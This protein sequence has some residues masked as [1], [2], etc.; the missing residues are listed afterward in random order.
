MRRFGVLIALT[1]LVV[2][3]GCGSSGDDTKATSTTAAPRSTTTTT[4]SPEAQ[5]LQPVVDAGLLRLTDLP[6]DFVATPGPARTNSDRIIKNLDQCEQFR[7]LTQHG[8]TSATSSQ[9]TNRTQSAFDTVDVFA[10]PA[11]AE[12]K[13]TL[14]ENPRII[15]C[16]AARYADPFTKGHNVLPKNVKLVGTD[17]SPLALGPAG[18]AING[19]RVTTTFAITTKGETRNEMARTDLIIFQVGAALVTMETGGTEAELAEIE[20][21]AIPKLVERLTAAAA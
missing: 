21:T 17:V 10:T 4:L 12:A 2:L 13:R 6:A 1:A 11:A 9:F 3:A 18:D 19:F 5:A 15:D 20:T 8:I 7:D 16:L 14:L